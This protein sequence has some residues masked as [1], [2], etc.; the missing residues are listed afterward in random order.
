MKKLIYLFSVLSL[1]VSITFGQQVVYTNTDDGLG[2]L[3]AA[4]TAGNLSGNPYSITFTTAGPISLTAVLPEITQSCTISGFSSLIPATASGGTTIERSMGAGNFCIFKALSLNTSLILQDLILQNGRGDNGGAIQAQLGTTGGLMMSRCLVRNNAAINDGGGGG[5]QLVSGSAIITDCQF[6]SNSALTY[7]G[8]AIFTGSFSSNNNSIS[9]ARC[10]FVNNRASFG[11]GVYLSDGQNR[12]VNCTFSNNQVT[13]RGGALWMNI[14]GSVD[15][16]HCSFVENSGPNGNIAAYSPCR[17]INCLLANNTGS[18]FATINQVTSLGGN[19][20]SSA[21]GTYFN[22]PSD[23][24]S[25]NLSVGPLQQNNSGLVSTHSIENCSPARDAGVTSAL[26]V[27]LP[28]TDA[29]NQPRTSPPDAGAYEVQTALPPT[30][31]GSLTASGPASC[32]SPAR[33]KAPAAGSSFVFTGPG[34]YIFSN[35]YRNSGSYA[36]FAD[37]V[38]LG[39][40]YT[41]TVSSGKGCPTAT[42]TVV[43]QGPTNCP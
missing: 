8:G 30:I 6:T 32:S 22:Q 18:N 9:F 35:V 29:N 20:S 21:D 23:K 1:S 27:N 43:V 24:N 11:G 31:A 10:T 13:S 25:Q 33:L 3:R 41:L 4:I 28:T 36:A 38:K 37:G 15:L 16:I 19:V 34:G 39:G 40:T 2:S 7:Y 42:S 12:L 17:L 14:V 26:G 5:L